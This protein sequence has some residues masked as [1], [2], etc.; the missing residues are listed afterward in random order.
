MN[1]I[2]FL[3]KYS[4]YSAAKTW[5]AENIETR[6]DPPVKFTVDGVCSCKLNWEKTV[7]SPVTVTDYEK[8]ST[9]VK[10]TYYTINY[11][12]KDLGL[13]VEVKVTS[14]PNYPV[15]EYCATL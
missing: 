15:V 5:L 10:R 7:G 2:E 11:T 3:E 9:P 13:E 4:D 8:T 1:R 12:E 6:N 14:Y